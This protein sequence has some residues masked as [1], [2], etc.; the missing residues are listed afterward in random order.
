[1]VCVFFYSN[2]GLK[3]NRIL[4]D[5]WLNG[6][7]GRFITLSIQDIFYDDHQTEMLFFHWFTHRAVLFIVRWLNQLTLHDRLPK[8]P[9]WMQLEICKGFDIPFH[10]KHVNVMLGW[11]ALIIDIQFRY[12][13]LTL[14]LGPKNTCTFRIWILFWPQ[15][16][17]IIINDGRNKTMVSFSLQFNIKDN[18]EQ[19]LKWLTVTS[20]RGQK[21]P[22]NQYFFPDYLCLPGH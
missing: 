19:T 18:V 5:H 15:R 17:S 4:G 9:W 10:H 16:N 14:R 3:F 1:M 7:M 11:D 6:I 8:L 13:L 22:Q 20:L 2:L 12:K 21:T